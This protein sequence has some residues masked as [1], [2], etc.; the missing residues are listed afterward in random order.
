MK[1]PY[2]FI[3]LLAIAFIGCHRYP[4]G[5]LISLRSTE[6]RLEGN[7]Q[8]VGFTS[9]GVDSLQYCIDSCGSLMNINMQ[10]A[11]G[12]YYFLTFSRNFGADWTF[13]D[14]KKLMNVTFFPDTVYAKTFYGVGLGPI[15][16]GTSS[17]WKILKLEMKELEISA[18]CNGC[19]YVMSFK[20]E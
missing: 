20:K 15:M 18:T 14:H 11:N 1:K 2:Y 17:Q 8:V 10:Q 16:E 4:D 12:K 9:N 3:I 5:P 7:W 6:G 13:S 19:N